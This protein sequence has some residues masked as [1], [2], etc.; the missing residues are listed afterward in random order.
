MIANIRVAVE[1]ADGSADLPHG[2]LFIPLGMAKSAYVVR[3]TDET[4]ERYEVTH[5]AGI[6]ARWLA[7]RLWQYR[8]RCCRQVLL[9]NHAG[10]RFEKRGLDR[11]VELLQSG[12]LSENCSEDWSDWHECVCDTNRPSAE[13]DFTELSKWISSRFEWLTVVD[14]RRME[15]H[16]RYAYAGVISVTPIDS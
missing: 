16:F 2:H 5:T 10:E 15:A 6:E 8:G 3:F 7:D 13:R 14:K 9:F 11:T 12:L 4:R 1:E